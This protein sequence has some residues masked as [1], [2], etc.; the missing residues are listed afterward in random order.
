[1]GFCVALLLLALPSVAR[2]QEYF[3]VTHPLHARLAEDVREGRT[4]QAQ[5]LM[6]ALQAVFVPEDLDRDY[7]PLSSTPLRC[8]TALLRA[9]GDPDSGLSASQLQS[10][11]EWRGPIASRRAAPT[12]ISPFGRFEITYHRSGV[13]SVDFTDLSPANGVPDYVELI[14]S[15]L[16]RSWTTQIYGLGFDAPET[17]GLPYQVELLSIGSFGFTELDPAAPGGTR[18]VLRNSYAGLPENE[19]PEGS[20]LGAIRVSCAHELRHAGQFATSGWSEPGLWI[21][22]DAVWM[23]DQVYDDVND[24]YRFLTSGS[25]ISDPPLPLDFGGSPSYP[26]SVLQHWMESRLGLD[27][28]RDYWERRRMFPGEEPIQSY[29]A[30]LSAGLSPLQSSFLDF[31][32]FNL[33]T[34]ALAD[35]GTGYPEAA[36]YPDARLA[37]EVSGL[38]AAIGSTVEHLAARFYRIDGFPGSGDEQVL[39]R[40]RQ[41]A[42][43]LLRFA[44]LTIRK[45]GSRTEETLVMSGLQEQFRLS[46]KASE[47]QNLYLLAANGNQGG[48]AEWFFAD[49]EIVPPLTPDP[50]LDLDS[51]RTDL[52]LAVGQTKVLSLGLDNDGPP[53]STLEYTARAVETTGAPRGIENST[54]SIDEPFYEAGETKRF[55]VGVLNGGAAL[56]FIS[57]VAIE[58]PPGINI[59]SGGDIT[60]EAG[61]SLTYLGLDPATR[62][63][64]WLDLDGGTGSVPAGGTGVGQVEMGFGLEA[65]G[66]V[67]LDWTLAGDGFG[68]GEQEVT[69]QI[70]LDGPVSP[71]LE[72]LFPRPMPP[73]LVGEP[74][75]VRWISAES[76]PVRIELARDGTQDW[77]VL[78]ESTPNDGF[79]RWTVNAPT[80]SQARLRVVAK[81]Q[82]SAPSEVFDI[83]QPVPWATIL[84]ESGTLAG[85][86]GIGLLLQVDATGLLPGTY[87]VRVDVRDANSESKASVDVTV[88]VLASAVDTPVAAR[89]R[90]IGVQPNPFN[91]STELRFELARRT[92]VDAEVL[93]LR[94]RLIRVL[95]AET[96]DPGLGAVAWDGR[97]D[98]GRAVASG[99]YLWRLRAD[100]REFS[101]KMSLVR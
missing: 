62:V 48:P 81:G 5:A 44:A 50:I 23:E 47:V 41:P 86:A 10:L 17:G 72:M 42:E 33:Q 7:A 57:R 61:L 36:G 37:L 101:G 16:E 87:P 38:P 46:T 65:T 25:P 3:D 34:G 45:D 93:D 53:T 75:D 99:T 90:V 63:V 56:G 9:A 58:I 21:E 64:Q 79:W 52:T 8:A 26:E 60:S 1:V 22:I 84:P 30:V 59:V 67:L 76:G 27:A 92:R 54:L 6:I 96:M 15:E 13:D 70:V 12:Y 40:I 29:D 82:A 73:G 100:G 71:R 80:T 68:G 49:V 20:E 18:I 43:N 2:A 28:I 77:E 32:L 91:P 94:G 66:P 39:V 95:A 4:T 51:S 97:D 35:P 19:D 98:A 14:G 78:V 83:L 24:Y 74:I 89:T 88:N 55:S 85:S 31:A 69:G 11:R